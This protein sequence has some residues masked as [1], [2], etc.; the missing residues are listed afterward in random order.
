MHQVWFVTGSSRGFGRAPRPAV[1][2]AGDLDAATA[3]P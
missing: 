2:E 3:P 1:F